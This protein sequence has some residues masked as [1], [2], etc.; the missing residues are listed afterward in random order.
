MKTVVKGKW[1]MALMLLTALNS[2]AQI[3]GLI[4][5][6]KDKAETKTQKAGDAVKDGDAATAINAGGNSTAQAED[7]LKQLLGDGSY[8]SAAALQ[9]NIPALYKPAN[10]Y[11][12]ATSVVGVI[13]KEQYPQMTDFQ[14]ISVA[15]AKQLLEDGRAMQMTESELNFGN[16]LAKVIEGTGVTKNNFTLLKWRNGLAGYKIISKDEC[17]FIYAP[18]VKNLETAFLPQ[19]YRAAANGLDE[20]NTTFDVFTTQ[21]AAG[22]SANLMQV[23]TDMLTEM[24]SFAKSILDEEKAADAEA[25]KKAVFPTA[26]MKDPVLEKELLAIVQKNGKELD[27]DPANLKK[28][29]I[30]DRDW[31]VRRNDL[32]VILGKTLGVTVGF[33]KD[34]HCYYTSFQVQRD[35]EGGDSYQK[36]VYFNGFTSRW[37]EI[38]CE[39]IK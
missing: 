14:L 32:G 27:F 26:G 38:L 35:Y 37:T 10:D 29:I 25:A 8:Y 23:K 30:E 4:R 6:V 11:I 5:K 1:I 39:N 9:G 19:C 20:T 18:F 12:Q 21:R 16:G 7:H 28:L 15:L 13:I 17:R 36:T 33:S 22:L 3:G 24:K 34:G 2:T 31:S